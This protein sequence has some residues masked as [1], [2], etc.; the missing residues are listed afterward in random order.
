[1]LVKISQIHWLI[2]ETRDGNKSVIDKHA[3]R[4]RRSEHKN[5]KVKVKNNSSQLTLE[6]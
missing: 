2:S 6:F 4:A 1:M 3:S 5:I